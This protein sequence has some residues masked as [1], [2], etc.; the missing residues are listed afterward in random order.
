MEKSTTLTSHEGELPPAMVSTVNLLIHGSRP[1]F[2]DG[3][4]MAS[5]Y[6]C[7]RPL[8]EDRTKHSRPAMDP[9]QKFEHPVTASQEIGWFAA[10][11]VETPS[12]VS[13]VGPGGPPRMVRLGQQGEHYYGLRSTDVTR[14]T[15]QGGGKPPPR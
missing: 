4:A 8:R 14:H 1:T 11:P 7:A 5:E 13:T 6:P 10:K 15:N 2:M 12:L 9:S 3:A